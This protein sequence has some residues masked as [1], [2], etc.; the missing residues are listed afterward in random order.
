VHIASVLGSGPSALV[1]AGRS[2]EAFNSAFL[3]RHRTSAPHIFA[4]ARGMIYVQGADGSRTDVEEIVFHLTREEVQADVPVSLGDL[5]LHVDSFSASVSNKHL[6]TSVQALSF[7]RDTLGSLSA[8]EFR[9]ACDARFPHAILFKDEEF[10]TVRASR[11]FD[12]V[13]P[14]QDVDKSEELAM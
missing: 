11:M 5:V 1:L 3:Q 10:A 4:A 2:L 7:L 9:A 6:Q 14:S 8:Q 13:Q 12:S